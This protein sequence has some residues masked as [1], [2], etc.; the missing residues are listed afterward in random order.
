MGEAPLSL[1]VGACQVRSG[2]GTLSASGD[3]FGRTLVASEG[4]DARSGGGRLEVEEEEAPAEE[5]DVVGGR[6]LRVTAPIGVPV[7]PGCVFGILDVARPGCVSGVLP[8]ELRTGWSKKPA[9]MSLFGFGV[10]GGG[11]VEEGVVVESGS[12]GLEGG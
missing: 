7:L 12:V 4:W 2:I 8:I 1:E 9:K 10:R 6:G 11:L 5:D 3:H